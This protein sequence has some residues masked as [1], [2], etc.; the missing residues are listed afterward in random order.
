MLAAPISLPA[1]SSSGPRP[2]ILR[3]DAD[4]VLKLL[5]I[6]FGPLQNEHGRRQIGD[7]VFIN[8]N[9]PLLYRLTAFSGKF[10]PGFVWVEDGQI[11]GNVTLV[12]SQITGRYL[13]ANVAVHPDYRR[14]GFGRRLLEE[15]IQYIYNLNGRDIVLQVR[16]ENSAA[17]QLY[18]SLGFSRLGAMKHWETTTSRLRPQPTENKMAWPVRKLKSREWQHAYALD[19][20]SVNPDLTW[21]LPPTR[22][23][24][25]RGLF[26]KID[27]FLNA[28]NDETWVVEK[29]DSSDWG[30]NLAGLVNL[31]SEWRRPLRIEL[32]VHPKARGRIEHILMNKGLD[33]LRSWRGGAI[34][35]NHPAEDEIVNELLSGSNF[36]KRE[37]LLVMQLV[38]N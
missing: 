26:S 16:Q 25:N 3:E 23:K 19:K 21:P 7:R 33:R 38:L 10:Q 12:K 4:S 31:K 30:T 13:I 32:R 14:M 15:T 24:Y 29:L 35:M 37:I 5:D 11:I 6:T 2:I 36:T 1:N 9:P 34:R 28:Q 18:E 27:N 22:Q 8:L 20:D 17:I